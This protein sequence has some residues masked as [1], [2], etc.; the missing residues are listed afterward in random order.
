M[1]YAKLSSPSSRNASPSLSF[2][3]VLRQ[4]A[5]QGPIY[6]A[7]L[8]STGTPTMTTGTAPRT[9]IRMCLTPWHLPPYPQ[10]V[11]VKQGI[12]SHSGNL[13]LQPKVISVQEVARQ[14][15]RSKDLPLSQRP[16]L[17]TT[18]NPENLWYP[19][20]GYLFPWWRVLGSWTSPSSLRGSPQPQ[21]CRFWMQKQ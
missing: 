13:V 3:R 18:P 8:Q 10:C 15:C 1:I 12:S 17:F 19:R 21:C 9:Q 4:T 2:C 6:L 5:R 16:P 7:L 20:G 14:P 11:S